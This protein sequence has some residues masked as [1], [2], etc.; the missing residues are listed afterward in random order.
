MMSD[1]DFRA[2]T[3]LALLLE[4]RTGLHYP[5]STRDILEGKLSEHADQQG[6]ETL[7][8]Y[9]R[10][11][12]F[13]D[14][15]GARMDAL[16]DAIVVGETYF[17]RERPG[18]EQIVL[19]VRDRATRGLPSRIWSAACA[20]GEE[21]LSLAILLAEADLLH[22]CTFLATDLSDRQI[23]RAKAG[24]V[25][26]RALRTAPDGMPPWLRVVDGRAEVDPAIRA[27]IDWRK[28]NLVDAGAVAALGRFDF[29]LCRNVL[30]YFDDA[31]VVE[32]VGSL[33]RALE[34][35]GILLIGATESI[36]RFGVG[37]RCIEARGTFLY[38]RP[39][40]P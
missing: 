10:A 14:P 8:D 19:R 2:V 4:H 40:E 15:T 11:L 35:G 6:F 20:T 30:I 25:T 13:D 28:V 34:P 23:A 21:I 33:T 24:L 18:L 16:V 22:Y 31:R 37:L 12:T 27:R 9:H 32:V 29:I 17:F 39:E 1:A 7:T 36:L 3:L 26:H 5:S 38:Q